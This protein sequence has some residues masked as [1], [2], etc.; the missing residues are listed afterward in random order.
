[1]RV[2]ALEHDVVDADPVARLDATLVEDEATEDV[3]AEQVGRS[4]VGATGEGFDALDPANASGVVAYLASP[5]SSWLTG[6]VL[7]IEGRTLQRMQ[8]W[9]IDAMYASRDGNRLQAEELVD[10]VPRR[11]GTMPTGLDVGSMA[12]GLA[13]GPT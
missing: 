2:V 8:G 5:A 11:Y 1:M 12:S 4:H 7:R 6:Q 3:P 13:A 9:T 10:A